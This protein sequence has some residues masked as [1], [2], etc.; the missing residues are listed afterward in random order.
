MRIAWGLAA[1]VF[2]AGLAAI[3]FARGGTADLV[4]GSFASHGD[5]RWRNG[6]GVVAPDPCA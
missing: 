2:V 1:V 5:G 3:L 6:S 4:E